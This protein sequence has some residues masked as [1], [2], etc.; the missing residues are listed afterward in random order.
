MLGKGFF[1]EKNPLLKI[2]YISSNDNLFFPFEQE[3]NILT[4][5]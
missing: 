5:M 2:S 3:Q 4:S 1:G